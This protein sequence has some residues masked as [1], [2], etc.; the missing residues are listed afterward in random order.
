MSKRKGTVVTLSEVMEEVGV[1]AVRYYLAESNPQNSIN[2]DLELAKRTSRENPAFYI[3]YAHA[4]CCA[5]LRKALESSANTE[6][7]CVEPAPV[8]EKEWQDWLLKFKSQSDT[9]HAGF[10]SDPKI[11]E[12]QKALVM[13]L[14]AFPDEV[15]EATVSRQPGRLARYA[16][17]VANAL[18]KFYEVSRVISDDSAVT[19]AR[20]GIIAATKQVLSNVLGII[21]VSAPERM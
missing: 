16:F 15:T 10:D 9:F 12:H 3:Q 5:I 2:F 18:Q 6:S 14:A 21:G 1:D 7:K 13:C 11:F 20:L 19:G 17:D 4:R 8:S